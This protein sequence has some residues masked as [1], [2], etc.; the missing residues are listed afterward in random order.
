[1]K[2]YKRNH[3]GQFSQDR[4]IYKFFL[5]MFGVYAVSAIGVNTIWGWAKSFEKA[6]VVENTLAEIEY[7]V[8]TW[9][10]EVLIMVENAG[11]D[12]DLASKIIQHESWWDPS[13]T[14]INKDGSRDRGLWMISEVWHP[15]V[16]D[17]CAYDYYCST[18]QAIR[19]AK[20]RGWDEWIA[21][22]HGYVK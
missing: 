2:K 6:F 1:M 18:L 10:E 12:K 7:H 9:Q 3:R 13:N 16:T 8:P 20:E 22:K 17:S 21:Y 11:L 15:E 5:I 19:I 4:T 14:H